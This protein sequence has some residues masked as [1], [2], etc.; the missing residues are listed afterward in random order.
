MIISVGYRVKSK[1]GIIF[2]RQA[3]KILKSYLLE[4]YA[5]NKKRLDYLQKQINLIDIA[6][7]LDEKVT[8]VDGSKI[9][10]VIIEYKKALDLLD[11]YDH[12][13]LAKPQGTLNAV[14]I[15]YEECKE[16]ID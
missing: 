3:N 8:S 4:G 14:L 15:T 6:S 7:R 13:T 2:R 10:D 9:L 16:I 11:D 1:R 5:V 12:R